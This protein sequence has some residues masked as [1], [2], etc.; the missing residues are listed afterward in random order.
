MPQ[1]AFLKMEPLPFSVQQVKEDPNDYS[2][3]F[4]KS[5]ENKRTKLL[6][7]IP[8]ERLMDLKVDYA[9]KQLFG[10]E[11]NKE[12]TVVFL[13]AILQSTGRNRIKD[14]SF[15]NTESG[16]EYVD[17]KQSRLDLL[18]VT[19][20]DE[21]INVEIQFTNK[22]DMIKRSI[23][24]WAGIYRDPLQK[25][26]AYKELR[27]VITINIM[28][29]RLFDQ[30][31]RF[32]TTYHLFEDEENFQLTNVMEFHFIEMSKL[33]KDWKGDKLDPWNNILARWLLMLGMVDHRNEKVYA[34]IY[35]EL[36]EISVK[37][38]SLR[39]A[40]QHWEELSMSREQYLAYQSRLKRVMD[41]EAAQ[42]EAELKIQEA[43]QKSM[44]AEQKSMDAEQKSMDA[45]QK[46]NDAEKKAKEAELKAKHAESK[47]NEAEL[48]AKH[49][50]SKA[51][52][53]ELK[54][55]EAQQ[56]MKE[57]EQKTKEAIQAKEVIASRLLAKGMN[58]EE[59]A[60]ATDLAVDRVHRVQQEIQK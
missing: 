15:T 9:F 13:N 22:Y 50:E 29:F 31:E 12:I 18:V 16:G 19:D 41:E 44:D 38:E 43:E 47:A 6:K 4:S 33:I 27:P 26:M 45:E 5:N 53:A 35:H 34:D 24:Y 14:I 60:V 28:N 1:T 54:I 58:V 7:R 46:F 40:F 49:A 2:K 11:K 17:D 57:A 30:T 36:E 56:K 25:G 55:Q 52:E 3:Q 48:K 39:S 37:D 10:N 20:A 51:N 42:R 21:S 32:H 8:L 59:V 23:Y